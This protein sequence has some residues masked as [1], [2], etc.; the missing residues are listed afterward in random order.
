M[1][2]YLLVFHQEVDTLHWRSTTG[3]DDRQLEEGSGGCG[4]RGL[5]QQR[6]KPV[7]KKQMARA[8]GL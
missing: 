6:G 3:A 7:V 4:V 8:Q 1:I 5:L 2:V